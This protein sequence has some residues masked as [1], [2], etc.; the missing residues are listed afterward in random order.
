VKEEVTAVAGLENGS[1]C[2]VAALRAREGDSLD[3]LSASARETFS[4]CCPTSRCASLT[5]RMTE[6]TR[7]SSAAFSS[8][9]AWRASRSSDTTLHQ[10]SKLDTQ[11]EHSRLKYI[12]WDHRD[13]CSCRVIVMLYELTVRLAHALAA[14]VVVLP[15]GRQTW[16]AHGF[17]FHAARDQTCELG[18]QVQ[19]AEGNKTETNK[20]IE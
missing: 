16:P 17:P 11:R 20:P 19:K 14:A 18:A 9:V 12:R 7:S 10:C 4:A 2:V 1:N 5:P 6:R 15:T 3:R 8:A 13:D